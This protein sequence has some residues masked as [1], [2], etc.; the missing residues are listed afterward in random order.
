MSHFLRKHWGT[1]ATFP[2]ATLKAI[3]MVIT[4]T[5]YDERRLAAYI[6]YLLSSVMHDT[7]KW[8][9]TTHDICPQFLRSSAEKNTTPQNVWRSI[10]ESVDAADIMKKYSVP[11]TSPIVPGPTASARTLTRANEPLMK[12]NPSPHTYANMCRLS[13]TWA[14]V[15]FSRPLSAFRST[16]YKRYLV[17]KKIV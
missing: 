9:P 14:V 3:V 10:K 17:Q 15:T 1:F 12:P 11:R 13:A 8:D 6:S 16:Q 2:P 4:R 7:N 5:M